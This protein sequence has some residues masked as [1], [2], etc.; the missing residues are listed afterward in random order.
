MICHAENYPKPAFSK[1]KNEFNGLHT[2]SLVLPGLL[3]TDAL[4]WPSVLDGSWSSTAVAEDLRPTATATEA[5]VWGHS[6]GRRS[7]LYFSYHGLQCWTEGRS[8]TAVAEDLRPTATA[9]EA[10]PMAVGLIC[11]FLSF[12]PKWRLK[13]VFHYTGATLMAL[14]MANIEITMVVRCATFLATILWPFLMN[15]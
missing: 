7:Y 8:S 10:I 12:F 3:L 5:E 1:A 2:T 4:P 11:T 14:K 13:C 15:L 6:Y 9:T